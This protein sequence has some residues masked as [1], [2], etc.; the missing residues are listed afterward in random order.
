MAWKLELLK[1]LSDEGVPFIVIG[2][3]AAIAHG[4]ARFTEDLDLCAPLD[5]EHAQRIIKALS[6]A[7]PKWRMRPDLPVVTPDNPNLL[8]GLKN[9]YLRTD[10]GQL[11]VLGE[12]PG[13]GSYEQIRDRAV[14]MEV[15]D[16]RCKILDLDTLIAAKRFAGREKDKPTVRELE[17]I[18]DLR[19]K[20]G[21]RG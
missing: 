21:G 16:I 2:G 11:D 4:S 12:L 6:E 7:K 5:P 10:W 9:M 19:R 15:F 8:A 3:V 14:Q 1:R 17:V 18:R 13:I 20:D